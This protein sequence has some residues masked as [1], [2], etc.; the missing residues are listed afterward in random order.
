M[1][2][3]AGR[4]SELERNFQTRPAPNT[5]YK[6]KQML[7]NSVPRKTSE[8]QL[9]SMSS[10]R[11]PRANALDPAE[12]SELSTEKKVLDVSDPSSLA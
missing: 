9:N 1:V 10:W 2:V 4:V 7:W 8:G 12:P 3:A 5:N 6:S 11:R